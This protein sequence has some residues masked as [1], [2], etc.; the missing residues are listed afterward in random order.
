MIRVWLTYRRSEVDIRETPVRKHESRAG[1]GWRAA[2]S[3]RQRD[4]HRSTG[5]PHT[6]V[7]RAHTHAT[8]RTCRAQRAPSQWPARGTNA[9]ERAGEAARRSGSCDAERVTRE[10]VVTRSGVCAGVALTEG[11]LLTRPTRRSVQTTTRTHDGRVG[12]HTHT[13]THGYKRVHLRRGKGRPMVANASSALRPGRA[14][15]Q[16]T[17]ESL[18]VPTASTSTATVHV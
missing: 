11:A 6:F 9:P 16:Y 3:P 14:T 5:T 4:H 13:E 18:T 7:L 10:W 1:R 12:P 8:R 17:A 15:V 2:L